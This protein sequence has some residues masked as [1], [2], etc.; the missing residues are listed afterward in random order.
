MLHS[1]FSVY[2]KQVGQ[3]RFQQLIVNRQVKNIFFSLVFRV[4]ALLS[5]FLIVPLLLSRFSNLEYGIVVTILSISTWFTFIDFGLANGL[6]NKIS[7]SLANNDHVNVRKYI[8]TAYLTLLK[9]VICFAALLLVA[10]Q[11]V[12]WNY[13]LEGPE[14]LR[15]SVNLLVLYGLLLFF[16]KII[17]EL[18]NPVLLAFHKTAVSS[19]I[20]FVSQLGI[21]LICYLYKFTN[22]NSLLQYGLTFFWVPLVVVAAFSVYFYLGPLKNV[23]PSARFLET[24][25]QKNLLKL[26]GSFFII[27]IAVMIIFTTD[28]LIVGKIF[29]YEEVGR[30]NIAFRY[31]NIPLMVLAIML[32]PYWPIFSEWFVARNFHGVKR[33]MNRLLWVWI[34]FVIV[35][36][37]MLFSAT[38][39]YRIWVGPTV[40]IPL[41]L[42]IGM[43]LFA[44]IS[45]WNSIFATFINST[46]KLRL[47][48]YSCVVAGALN[49]PVSVYLAKHTFLGPA[50]V[51]YGTC[52][53]L[54][55]SSVWAP[56]QYYKLVNNRAGGIWNK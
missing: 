15:S 26:G 24:R 9:V 41:I 23:A 8:S 6:K 19:L 34:A 32:T 4:G 52:I 35:S 28:N 44:I 50:G 36:V 40:S 38:F 49:V 7:E 56:I 25:Y 22:I 47:Q 43:F 12:D 48:L 3:I 20:G 33:M 13:L 17:V 5:N 10:H 37:A 45:G 11:F 21:L 18:I 39:V 51:I 46:N 54:I 42:N 29:G 30:Y 53:C 55:L 31:F 14:P 2:L 16:G 1:H 27:Q